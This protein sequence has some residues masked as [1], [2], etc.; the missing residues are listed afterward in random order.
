M[1]K[2]YL[3]GAG[4]NCIAAIQFFKKKNIIA[5]IDNDE[6]KQGKYI[7]EIPIISLSQYLEKANGEQIII[8]GFMD[9]VS[10][11]DC[12]REKGIFN[13]YY[14]PYMQT[15]FYKDC[16]DIIL[17]L[18]LKEY[19]TIYFYTKNPIAEIIEESFKENHEK[20]VI[21]YLRSCEIN[22]I[23]EDM[24]IL[25]T[26]QEESTKLQEILDFTQ[27]YLIMDIN[28]IYEKSYGF[29]NERILKFK[30]IHKRKRCFIIGNGPSLRYSDLELLNNKKEIC[31][32]VNRIYLSYEFTKWRPDYYVAID[33]MVVRN[34]KLNIMK[35][36]GIKF[37]RYFYKEI[38][39]LRDENIY[40]FRG[41]SYQPGAPQFSLDMYQGI[42]MGNT[43]VFDA[44]QIAYYMGFSEI[45]LLGVDMTTGIRC[46]EDGSHFYKIPDK[47]EV[48]GLG[49]MLEA[50]RCLV[51]AEQTIEELGRKLRN[52]TRGGELDEVT[53]VN[54]DELFD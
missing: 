14:C 53:R 54:F 32:G 45:Y 15:G 41:L 25:I 18:E 50:R 31:F 43:V 23:M 3:F 46:E 44:I 11:S 20:I 22:N 1:G 6:R 16:D 21:R 42:Y 13:F 37:I 34:D 51:Y 38:E 2:Y 35:M 33:Y 39:G 28:E 47:K 5:V 30:D 36:D 52:A 24:P 26:N 40:E 7:E 4:I 10:I 9:K 27:N 8:T 12:L 17:K 29:K 49:N 48:L 19:K